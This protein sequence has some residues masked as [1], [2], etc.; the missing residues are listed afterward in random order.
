[1]E[2]F[3]KNNSYI[4]APPEKSGANLE[5]K[6]LNFTFRILNFRLINFLWGRIGID[7]KDY[8]IVSMSGQDCL[9]WPNSRN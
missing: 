2:L 8:F 9:P 5:D 7:R 4:F 6:L 1:M 3:S